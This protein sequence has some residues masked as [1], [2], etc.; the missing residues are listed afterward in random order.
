VTM[1]IK[2]GTVV[3]RISGIRSRISVFEG[4][5]LYLRTNYLSSDSGNAEMRFTRSDYA[6]VPEPHVESSIHELEAK[7][8]EFRDELEEW[9]NLSLDAEETVEGGKVR[10]KKNKKETADGTVGSNQDQPT[11]IGT[12]RAQ[13]G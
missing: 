13:A 8:G 1:S 5:V 9:E 11:A 6:T 4:L 3:D 2:A 10:K 12:R 7:I